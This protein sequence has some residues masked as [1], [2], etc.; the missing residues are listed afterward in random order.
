MSI[1]KREDGREGE[2]GGVAGVAAVEFVI[3]KVL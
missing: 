1:E 3:R 2:D